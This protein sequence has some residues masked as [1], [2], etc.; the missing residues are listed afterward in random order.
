MTNA[1]AKRDL[2]IQQL[3]M[4]EL[5]EIFGGQAPCASE[6]DN[7]ALEAVA[8][9]LAMAAIK[10]FISSLLPDTFD[11]FYKVY[12]NHKTAIDASIYALGSPPVAAFYYFVDKKKFWRKVYEALK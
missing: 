5:M 10:I 2:N 9:A 1:S 7:A 11:E 3:N 8:I 4:E 6:E 12:S